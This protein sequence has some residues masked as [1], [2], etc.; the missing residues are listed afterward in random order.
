MSVIRERIWC[1]I[2]GL[3][4]QPRYRLLRRL[5]AA[6]RDARARCAC[7]SDASCI[8]DGV[9]ERLRSLMQHAE[10]MLARQA[11]RMLLLAG[12]Q[13]REPRSNELTCVRIEIGLR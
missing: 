8:A 3:S 1:T 13:F 7:V 11:L 9:P 6:Q 10:E 5:R 12:G 2:R 4:P